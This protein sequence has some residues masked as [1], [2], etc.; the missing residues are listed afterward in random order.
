MAGP[1]T[2][3][4][5]QLLRDCWVSRCPPEQRWLRVSKVAE[6][7][8]FALEMLDQAAHIAPGDASPASPTDQVPPTVWPAEPRCGSRL[9]QETSAKPWNVLSACVQPSVSK[10]PLHHVCCALHFLFKFLLFQSVGK[11]GCDPQN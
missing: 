1:R 7:F 5:T 9:L 6:S 2:L 11:A 10:M 4:G 3:Q 8:H